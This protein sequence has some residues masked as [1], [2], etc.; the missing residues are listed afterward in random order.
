MGSSGGGERKREHV[1][2]ANTRTHTYTD[3]HTERDTQ[4]HTP[5]NHMVQ[6]AG[7]AIFKN[8]IEAI[9]VLLV[10]HLKHP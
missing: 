8:N 1:F 4:T 6:R 9:V 7:I 10:Q 3:T 5:A 2:S